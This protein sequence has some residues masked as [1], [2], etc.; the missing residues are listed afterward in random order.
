MDVR[1]SL[2]NPIELHV[3]KMVYDELFL[4]SDNH[5]DTFRKLI[6]NED[7]AFSN[8]SRK[9]HYDLFNIFNAAYIH[10]QMWTPG[11]PFA[12]FRLMGKS[13]GLSVSEIATLL[14]SDPILQLTT[15]MHYRAQ[16]HTRRIS[17]YIHQSES[18]RIEFKKFNGMPEKQTLLGKHLNAQIIDL[19]G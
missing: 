5:T 3:P 2:D 13:N 10:E 7:I 16:I 4:V 11:S 17:E 6:P 12:I 9:T 8:V 14:N 18:D 15:M 1:S 19:C